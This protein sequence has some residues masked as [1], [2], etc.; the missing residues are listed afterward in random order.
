MSTYSTHLA[1]GIEVLMI[2]DTTNGLVGVGGFGLGHGWRVVRV[3]SS[4]Q[5]SE[6][7]AQINVTPT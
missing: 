2:E 1:V 7:R 6:S 4:V 3:D 5:V